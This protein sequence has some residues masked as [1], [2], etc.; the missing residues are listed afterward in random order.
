M[1]ELTDRQRQ[2]LG[3]WSRN[4]LR[5]ASRSARRT[6]WRGP[7]C[8]SLRL[9][10][11]AS[12]PSSSGWG[13]SHTPTHR[14]GG[15]RPRRAIA[16]TRTRCSN[17]WSRGRARFRSTWPPRA[18]SSRCSSGDDRD[19]LAGDAPARTRLG[20]GAADGDRPP[21][22]GARPAAAGPDGRRDHVDR[23]RVQAGLTLADAGRPGVAVWAGE[24]LNERLTGLELGSG[25]L[26]RRRFEE[27]GLSR[28]EP[29]FLGCCGPHSPSSSAAWS[30]GFSSAEPQA[31]SARCG[32]TSSRRASDCSRRWRSARRSSRCSA[33]RSDRDIHTSGSAES[34]T[35]RRSARSP[36]SARRTASRT[37]HSAPS[38]CSGRSGWTTRRRSD[39]VRAAG[40]ELS[41]FVESVYEDNYGARGYPWQRWR[42]PVVTTTKSSESIARLAQPIS[43]GPFA[44]SRAS[45]IPMCPMSLMRTS[46]SRKSSRPTRS[47]QVRDPS[48]LRS[49][50]ARGP[51][52]R[53]LPA[54]NIRLRKPRR[55][56]L[57]V[58]R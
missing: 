58:L 41:R 30:S 27:P 2:I 17:G 11:G 29:A 45:S 55:H 43:S 19:A 4:T 47:S 20:T 53:W 46:A 18:A 24:Y 38:A 6:S 14:R 44:G 23:R 40:D 51:A 31:C 52:Q 12:S 5:P 8:P 50:R 48:A 42:R 3:T 56:L 15:S 28:R 7:A 34:S 49:F 22:R 10:S 16:P 39:P 21:R 32:R 9:P 13:C 57:R 33:R 36:S 37:E 35:T 54:D 25:Q 26:R 1:T